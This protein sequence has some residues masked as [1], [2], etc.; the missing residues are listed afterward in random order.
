[1][2]PYHRRPGAPH[3][4][5]G[6]AVPLS[7]EEI[8]AALVRDHASLRGRLDINFVDGVAYLRGSVDSADQSGAIERRVK[9]FD[10]VEAVLNLLRV[11]EAATPIPPP[12]DLAVALL[13]TRFARAHPELAERALIAAIVPDDIYGGG[14]IFAWSPDAEDEADTASIARAI[15]QVAP[16]AHVRVLAGP[17]DAMRLRLP[18]AEW[19]PLYRRRVLQGHTVRLDDP[20]EYLSKA[21][22]KAARDHRA[23]QDLADR[24]ARDLR[25]PERLPDGPE[26]TV[27]TIA[28][29]A[30]HAEQLVQRYAALP[31]GPPITPDRCRLLAGA[32]VVRNVFVA[33][34]EV[35]AAN[36][37]RLERGGQLGESV[38]GVMERL[39]RALALETA[40]FARHVGDGAYRAESASGA[41][42]MA[43]AASR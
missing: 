30:D 22:E 41:S 38:A 12:V 43:H 39:P 14:L 35:L 7:S 8:E 26:L 3:L 1:L 31:A 23:L 18:A 24:L 5:G 32:L 9:G 42:R 19:W 15:G 27:A 17:L 33:A 4:Y 16:R 25:E 10:G 40:R 11:P 20:T 29:V 6:A 13:R 37:E 28:L 21:V 34:R 36:W 2:V